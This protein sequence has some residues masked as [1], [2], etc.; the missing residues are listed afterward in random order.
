M[1]S[2]EL[3]DKIQSSIEGMQDRM[4][5]TY[6]KLRDEKISGKSMDET[7][8]VILTATY[9]F[10]DIIFTEKALEGGVKEF[11]WRIREAFKAAMEAVQK[12]TQAQT[13]EL[14][15][16]MDIPDEIKNMELPVG[17]PAQAEE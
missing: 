13:L 2:N 14:L 8:E 6:G 7:V 16:G 9:D 5:D 10:G 3:L 1:A 17:K 11:K 12:V 4:K 15:Q